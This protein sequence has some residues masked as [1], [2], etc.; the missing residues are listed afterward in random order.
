M[1]WY[2]FVTI[3]AKLLDI[4][5]YSYIIFAA[6]IFWDCSE[7]ILLTPSTWS[8]EE[9]ARI[10][11]R[12]SLWECNWAFWKSW[13]PTQVNSWEWRCHGRRQAVDCFPRWLACMFSSY[14]LYLSLE[15]RIAHKLYLCITNKILIQLVLC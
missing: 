6:W 4:L 1:K 3:M 10:A 2:L 9:V 7:H 13:A 14:M 12:E 8:F 5:S 15:Q 11:F